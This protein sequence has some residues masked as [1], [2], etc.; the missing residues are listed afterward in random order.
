MEHTWCVEIKYRQNMRNAS[1]CFHNAFKR[2]LEAT[3]KVF[4]KDRSEFR[5]REIRGKKMS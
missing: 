1:E 2:H 5:I 3:K 4:V